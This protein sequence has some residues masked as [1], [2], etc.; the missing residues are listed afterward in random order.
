[1]SKKTSKASA[2]RW[3]RNKETGAW[4]TTMPDALNGTELSADE[5]R[6]SCKLRYGFTPSSLPKI[7]GGC[8]ALFTIEH[9]MCCKKG[10]LVLHRHND[11]KAEWRYL[12]EQALSKKAVSDEPFI[13]KSQDVQ[14]AGASGTEPL[15]ELRGDVGAHGF[16]KDGMTTIFDVRVTDTDAPS[17]K[18]SDPIKVLKRQENE[19]N[20]VYRERCLQR[21]RHFTPL[22]FS[23]DGMR[24]TECAAASKRLAQLLAQKWQRTYSEVCGYVRSKLS[25]ALVR[26]ASR[27]LRSDRDPMIRY[28]KTGWESGSGLGLYNQ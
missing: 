17:Y 5:F 9:A 20:K 11:L 4:L 13:H 16:W 26:S 6:D 7:C 8:D 21:R 24:G 23:V 15:P 22:V 12:C 27:C 2:R 3:K 28:P 18:K 25:I 10:G 19:K 14:I 1:M